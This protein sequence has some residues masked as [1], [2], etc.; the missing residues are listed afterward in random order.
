MNG[1][2]AADQSAIYEIQIRGRLDPSWADWF[3]GFSLHCQGEITRLIGPVPDQA[4]LLGLLARIGQLNLTLL[5]KRL[6][7]RR[8]KIPPLKKGLMD[9]LM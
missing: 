3:D 5:K 2:H 7:M 6:A 1:S 4:A 8:F 9:C